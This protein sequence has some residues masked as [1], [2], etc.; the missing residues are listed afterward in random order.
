MPIIKE[1]VDSN[2]DN[3]TQKNS[4][5]PA[6]AGSEEA[7]R[8]HLPTI[9]EMRELQ[10]VGSVG[11]GTSEKTMGESLQEFNQGDGTPHDV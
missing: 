3:I 6:T 11:K 9:A 7:A 10:R 1:I 5:Y 2:T 8:P 4:R